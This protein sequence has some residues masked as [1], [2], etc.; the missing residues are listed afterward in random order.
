MPADL[1]RR[2]FLLGTTAL[3]AASA[4]PARLM[5][6]P[7][8]G[9]MTSATFAAGELSPAMVDARLSVLLDRLLNP[10]IVVELQKAQQDLVTFGRGA[11]HMDSAG[12]VR[13]LAIDEFEDLERR[14]LIP[15]S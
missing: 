15:R 4:A 2:R 3:V 11:V 14:G 7:I 5:Q 8:G 13:V 12:R 1:S 6:G 10:P 9:G